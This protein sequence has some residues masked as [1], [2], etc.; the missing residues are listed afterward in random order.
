LFLEKTKI[1][2]AIYFWQRWR[3]GHN[4]RGQG[5]WKFPRPRTELPRRGC[6][7]TKDRKVRGQGEGL[8]Y[9]FENTRKYKYKHC[10]YDFT[11]SQA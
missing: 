5:H 2:S 11:G 9:T 6:L 7:E 4:L 8:E 1:F 10:N 3:R